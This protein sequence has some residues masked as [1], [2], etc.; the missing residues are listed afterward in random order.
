MEN[1][2]FILEGKLEQLLSVVSQLRSNNQELSSKL[3][4]TRADNDLLREKIESAKTRVSQLIASIPDTE[5]EPNQG[6]GEVE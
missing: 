5:A 2:L 1:E 6:E 3:S 4:E